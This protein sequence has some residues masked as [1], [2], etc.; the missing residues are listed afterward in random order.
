MREIKGFKIDVGGDVPEPLR[1]HVSLLGRLLG[2]VIQEQA[3]E[4][5]FSLVEDLRNQ[6][7]AAEQTRD[8]ALVE[9][10]HR[11]IRTLDLDEIFW[12]IRSYTAFFTWPTR[13]N[14]RRSHASTAT[15]SAHRPTRSPGRV[16]HGSGIQSQGRGQSYEQ[17]RDLAA[18]IEIEPTL[19]ALSPCVRLQKSTFSCRRK[20]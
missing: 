15:P 17:V 19:K 11:R 13:P 14:A 6:A 18:R 10:M 1:Y 12:L 16:H 9:E 7:K 3:G 5:V 8:S 2:H 4:D 20:I